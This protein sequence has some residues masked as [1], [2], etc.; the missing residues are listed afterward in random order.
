LS[1]L[2]LLLLLPLLLFRLLAS[3]LLLAL[4]LVLVLLLV[5]GLD[6][7]LLSKVAQIP[8]K[9]SKSP[10]SGA[11]FIDVYFS[12]T[13]TFETRSYQG[14]FGLDGVALPAANA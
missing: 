10:F 8:S 14:L 5:D 13:A 7:R 12:A 1:V 6:G 2:L 4:Q 11:F 9:I 3:A